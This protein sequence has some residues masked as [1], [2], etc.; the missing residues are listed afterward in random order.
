MRNIKILSRFCENVSFF[1]SRYFNFNFMWKFYRNR[2][3][4][5]KKITTFSLCRVI[6]TCDLFFEKFINNT[7]KEIRKQRVFL[8]IVQFF[9]RI[10]EIAT[11]IFQNK[12][13]H[14]TFET[15]RNI[16]SN[17]SIEIRWFNSLIKKWKHLRNSMRN[18]MRNFVQLQKILISQ[19]SNHILF[20]TFRF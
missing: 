4:R 15:I 20:E 5:T 1:W 13:H 12:I 7:C 2:C 8:S 14:E 11:T 17:T 6:E 3:Y 16:K 18:W 10:V 19:Y 9:S